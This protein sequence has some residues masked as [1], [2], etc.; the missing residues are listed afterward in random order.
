M[1]SRTILAMACLA[2]LPTTFAFNQGLLINSPFA[3]P[4]A[5]A[6]RHL[7]MVQDVHQALL[8]RSLAMPS[9]QHASFPWPETSMLPFQEVVWPELGAGADT[10]TRLMELS[11]RP[12]QMAQPTS[13]PPPSRPAP[14]QQPRAIPITIHSGS[15][16]G[17]PAAPTQ[18]AATPTPGAR[19][20]SQAPSA[21]PPPRRTSMPRPPPA[22][23]STPS[24][25]TQ[26]AREERRAAR[27][28]QFDV[29][30]RDV[31]ASEPW[32]GA[33][34]PDIEGCIAS[35]FCSFTKEGTVKF[36]ADTYACVPSGDGIKGK[37]PSLAD[38][39]VW[40]KA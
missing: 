22:P 26:T 1:R 34:L 21:V 31:V 39:A 38:C 27:P 28:S 13:T 25:T 36:G 9:G 40:Y 3:D 4:F 8:P 6:R 11:E 19:Q 5:I 30:V 32:G 15:P 12:Q 37:A 18:A 16:S 23:V 2:L 24:A 20:P 14:P 17:A 35:G 29:E 10:V 7:S 33:S